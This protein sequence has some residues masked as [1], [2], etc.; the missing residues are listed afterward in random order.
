MG[1]VGSLMM[2]SLT[3]A[4]TPKAR[5]MSTDFDSQRLVKQVTGVGPWVVYQDPTAALGFTFEY[6]ENWAAG[7]ETGRDQPYWQLIIWAL[8]TPRTRGVPG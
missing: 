5:T 4:E 6:P 8:A 1:T 7:T 3:S 2:P